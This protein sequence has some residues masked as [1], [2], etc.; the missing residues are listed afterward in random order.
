MDVRRRRQEQRLS[1][2]AALDRGYCTQYDAVR[3]SRPKWQRGAASRVLVDDL[4]SLWVQNQQG[5]PGT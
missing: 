4:A 2:I 3:A 1:G 5:Q